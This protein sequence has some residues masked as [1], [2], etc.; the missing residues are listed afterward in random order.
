MGLTCIT[1]QVIH[2]TCEKKKVCLLGLIDIKHNTAN[3]EP[4]SIRTN[5]PIRPQCGIYYYEIRVVSKGTDGLFAIG[6][7]TA[8]AKL[9][10]LPGT[11]ASIH[12]VHIIVIITHINISYRL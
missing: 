3:K 7:C 2:N 6:F 10:T 5:F 11:V 8:K 1:I 9:N 12:H 4:A